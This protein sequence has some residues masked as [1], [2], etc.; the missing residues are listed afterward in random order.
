MAYCYCLGCSQLLNF[1]TCKNGESMKPMTPKEAK[2]VH[3]WLVKD[4]LI[5]GGL[6]HICPIC[7]SIK[8]VKE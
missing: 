5:Y 3:T 6:N 8:K 7:T 2:R 1:C 4:D